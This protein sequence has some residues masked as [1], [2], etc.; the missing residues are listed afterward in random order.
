MLFT[1]LRLTAVMAR[2]PTG[3][4]GAELVDDSW[5]EDGWEGQGPSDGEISMTSWLL[6]GRER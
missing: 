2:T 5:D 4:D 3:D 6:V 1:S